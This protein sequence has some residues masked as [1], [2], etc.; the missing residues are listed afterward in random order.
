MNPANLIRRRQ[1]GAAAVELALILPVLLLL[2]LTLLFIGMVFW[3]Y[4]VV[5]KASQDAARYLSSITPQEMREPVLAEQAVAVVRQIVAMETSD[6]YL[7]A[8]P[9]RVEVFCG[10][11]RECNGVMDDPLP[12]VVTVRVELRLKDIFGYIDTGR[13]GLPVRYTAQMAYTGT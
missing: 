8:G 6:L 1:N 13:Y 7:G 5:A 2:I 10:P 9:L 12:E 11:S 4:T 3:H